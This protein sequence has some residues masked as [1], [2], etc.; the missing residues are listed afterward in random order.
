MGKIQSALSGAITSI[1][2][3]AIAGKKISEDEK[4]VALQASKEAEAQRKTEEAVKQEASETALEADLIRMGA[5][6]ESAHAYMNARA[7]GLDT[8]NFGMIRRKGKIMG[9]YSS[10]AERLSKDALTDS[11][12]S[13]VIN[14]KG[15]AERVVSLG[16][17]RKG[18][19]EA[20]V[21]ASE[22]GKK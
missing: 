14:Q 15:F 11:L 2:A 9:T 1:G 5:D 6:P 10:V 4:Q 20:L 12:S 16:K 17:D 13:R 8:K 3:A 7:L 21:A 22:G 18:R 19:V